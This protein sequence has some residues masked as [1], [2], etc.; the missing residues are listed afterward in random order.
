MALAPYLAQTTSPE[1]VRICFRFQINGTSDPDA[2]YPGYQGVTDVS[3]S[4]AGVF[5]V[6]FA[7]KW[8]AMVGFTGTVLEATPAHDLIVK[9]ALA[10]YDASAG[11]LTLTVVGADGS[12]AAEDPVDNDWVYVECV[13]ARRNGL[14]ASVAI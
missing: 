9:A 4:G 7:E 10:G 8:S 1:L 3:R 2:L 14:Q 13:F 6:T 5:V 12:T 11:T